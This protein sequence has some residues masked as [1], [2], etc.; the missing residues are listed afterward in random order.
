MPLNESSSEP[1]NTHGLHQTEGRSIVS[2]QPPVGWDARSFLHMTSAKE[3]ESQASL[4]GSRAWTLWSGNTYGANHIYLILIYSPRV[5]PV[6][7]LQQDCEIISAG[8]RLKSWPEA[9]I[10]WQP[11]LHISR[12]WW[13]KP[14]KRRK[15]CLWAENVRMKNSNAF[16]FFS[17]RNRIN[18]KL[19][20]L[21]STHY[22]DNTR[23]TI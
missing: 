2:E 1:E 17:E 12:M 13:R 5:T 11:K 10:T 23:I 6:T 19:H 22:F 8:Q 16:P 7:R 21:V 4:S 15:K 9:L 14:V 18:K 3:Q 20:C